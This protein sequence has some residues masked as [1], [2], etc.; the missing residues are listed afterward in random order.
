[1]TENSAQ[2]DIA[3]RGTDRPMTSQ[4]AGTAAIPH[5]LRDGYEV[6]RAA[7]AA[8]LDVVLLP[9]Q[10]MLVG[11]GEGT[12]GRTAFSHG[13]PQDTT[14]AGAT[15]AQDKRMRRD[16]MSKA[17]YRVVKGATFSVGRSRRAA[18]RYAERVGFPVMIKPA[19]GDNMS[20]VIDGIADAEQLAEAVDSYVTPPADRPGYTRAAYALTELREPGVDEDGR[21]IV[22]PGYRF[23]VEKQ[24]KGQY[25][26]ALI[27]DGEVLAVLL[28][29]D[30]VNSTGEQIVDVT[31][32]VHSSVSEIAVGA[33]AAVPG[34]PL[35]AVDLVVPDHT[36]ETPARRAVIAEYSERPWLGLYDEAAPDVAA[37]VAQR[38][39]HH[40][41]PELSE[42]PRAEAIRAEIALEGA[43]DPQAMVQ[44]LSTYSRNGVQ[45]DVAVT[46]QAM[47][48]IGGVAEGA[49][50]SLAA[51]AETLLDEGIDGQRAMLCTLSQSGAV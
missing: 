34:V 49:S 21:V 25:L 23:I 26:R 19:I 47:G 18:R 38:L 4:D 37:R 12:V 36:A 51:L 44:A 16:L 5:A 40:S 27:L 9:R 14:L 48:R 7:L 32:M 17:G 33:A 11:E 2:K 28:F 6:H 45:L 24:P 29:A 8:G 35:S 10:V 31:E 39:L 50:D 46:D 41:I 1:M 43:V 15:F 3:Q 42:A 20:E 30:G 13:V 22:P